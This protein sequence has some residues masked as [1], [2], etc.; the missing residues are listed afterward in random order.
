MKSL[1]KKNTLAN[2]LEDSTCYADS[3]W[4]WT[5]STALLYSMVTTGINKTLPSGQN[6]EQCP[7]FFISV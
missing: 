3:G 1:Q 5:F 4:K 6:F 2:F 7:G